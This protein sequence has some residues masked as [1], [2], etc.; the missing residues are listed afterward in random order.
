MYV[1]FI[2]DDKFNDNSWPFYKLKTDDGCGCRELTIE[3]KNKLCNKYYSDTSKIE[4]GYYF[5]NGM[6]YPNK[7]PLNKVQNL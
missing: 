4:D 1:I 5:K 6:C 7:T 3:E 2:I